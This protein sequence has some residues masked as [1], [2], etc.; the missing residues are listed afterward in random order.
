MLFIS[1]RYLVSNR[2]ARAIDSPVAR[3]TTARTIRP[4]V[5]PI[6]I[7]TAIS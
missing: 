1:L 5:A 2:T 3:P 6:A 4:G 7:R